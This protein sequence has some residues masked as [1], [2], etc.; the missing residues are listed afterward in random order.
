MSAIITRDHYFKANNVRFHYRAQGSGPVLVVQSVGWGRS[1]AY[2]WSLLN[3]LEERFTVVYFEPR[4][5]GLSSKPSDETRMSSIFMAHDLENLRKELGLEA[6][7]ALH[8][9]TFKQRMYRNLLPHHVSQ[10][11]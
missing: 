11:S 2:L 4:A 7:P 9:W 10:T 8:L 5:N 6:F 3:P 1:A